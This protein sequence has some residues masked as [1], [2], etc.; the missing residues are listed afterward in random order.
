VLEDANIKL[1]AVA[2]HVLGQ[3]GRAMLQAIS[4]GEEDV[5]KLA[6]MAK[7]KLRKKIPPL[8]AAL[9]GTLRDHHR[10]LLRQWLT[11]LESLEEQIAEFDQEIERQNQPF[12]EIMERLT[13]IPGVDRITACALVAEIGT[14]MAQFPSAQNLAAW[15]ASVPVIMRAAGNA[16]AV[17]PE[18]A[19]RGCAGCCVK[20]LGPPHTLETRTCRLNIIDWPPSET[21]TARLSPWPTPSW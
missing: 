8:R 4:T 17:K 1:G 14:N 3:S 19:I 6:E 7:A 18:R 16:S 12:Q 10:F 5:D 13:A 9:T 15:G 20:L 21:R 11:Q 2:S